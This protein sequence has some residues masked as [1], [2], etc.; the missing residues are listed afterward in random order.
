VY[1]GVGNVYNFYKQIFNRNSID[2][3]GMTIVSSVHY[4]Q[5]YDN[6]FWN[7]QQMVYGDGD[8]QFL[9][10]DS[11]TG[12]QD[13]T[14]HELTHGVTQSTSNLTYQ[15]ESGGLNESMSDCFGIMVLQWVNNQT[16][17]QAD[18]L[19]GKGIMVEGNALRSMKDPGNTSQSF[20]GDQSIKNYSD[21]TADIDV[22]FSSGIGNYAFYLACKNTGGSGDSWDKIGKVWYVVNTTLLHAD[23]GFQDAANKTFAVAGSL[24]GEGSKEQKAVHD[25]WK[26]VG[27]EATVPDLT[28]SLKAKAR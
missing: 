19:I 10:K 23:S 24:F 18:W 14:A 22:H 9:R 28:I 6:A 21:F 16:I 11:L 8:D 1:Q 17:D 12:S 26:Q 25:A 20:S 2:N 13:I 4:G 27:L 15:G 5:E 3:N 7:G